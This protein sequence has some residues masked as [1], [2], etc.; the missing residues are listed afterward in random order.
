MSSWRWIF[1]LNVPLGVL[2]LLVAWRVLGNSG[3]REREPFDPQGRG[4][5]PSDSP[6]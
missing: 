6:H 4:C 1:Y 2:G 3:R 5:S